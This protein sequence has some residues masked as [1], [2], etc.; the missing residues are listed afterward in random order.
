[1]LLLNCVQNLKGQPFGCFNPCTN[2]R[3]E[4][5]EQLSPTFE[6]R[7]VFRSASQGRHEP[8]GATLAAVNPT[9]DLTAPVKIRAAPRSYTRGKSV[10]TRHC[11]NPLV[12]VLKAI[13]APCSYILY[14]AS[15]RTTPAST[16]GK[17]Q[18]HSPSDDRAAAATIQPTKN[19]MSRSRDT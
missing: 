14:F 11:E 2:R 6:A 8:R 16:A 9:H 19:P 5:E 12:R 15:T 4:S 13:A 7:R 3:P 1:C 10:G 18:V 17:N